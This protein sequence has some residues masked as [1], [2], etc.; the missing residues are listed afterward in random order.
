MDLMNQGMASFACIAGSQCG[1]AHHQ[2]NMDVLD[3]LEHLTRKLGGWQW[4][5]W[6]HPW[7]CPPARSCSPG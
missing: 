1:T 5:G 2:S 6:P 4:C 3:G 7:A